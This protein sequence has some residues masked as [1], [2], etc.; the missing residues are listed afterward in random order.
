MKRNRFFSIFLMFLIIA[1]AAGLIFCLIRFVPKILEYRASDEVFDTI[2]EEAVKDYDL[3]MAEKLHDEEK[4]SDADES[5]AD[6]KP[7]PDLTDAISVDWEAFSGGNYPVAWFQ[8]DDISYPVMQA[9]DNDYYLHRLP[10]GTYNYGGSL[11]LYSENSP[12]FTDQSSFIYGHNMNNGSMFGRLKNYFNEPHPGQRFYLYLPDGTRHT[13]QFFAV[14][15]IPQQS[16]AY[17]WSFKDNDSF[18]Q[19]QL[20]LKDVSSYE[21]GME[22]DVDG[23]FVTLSTC[24]G[25]SGTDRRLIVCGKEIAVDQ[26]QEPASWYD[27]YKHNYDEQVSALRHKADEL[28]SALQERQTWREDEILSVR[29]G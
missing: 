13:Y 3:V 22:T 17:T 23:I 26:L 9:E 2:K 14:A 5:V 29:H 8:M 18:L 15:T 11:F 6:E 25:L 27:G 4:E 12:M 20:F 21:C 24:N 28:D 7:A 19:W 16:Q 10:D 1:S